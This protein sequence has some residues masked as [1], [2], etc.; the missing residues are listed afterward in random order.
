VGGEPRTVLHVDMDAFFVAV[1]LLRRPELGGRP[2]VVGGAGRRGVVAAAS[3]EARAHGVFSAMPSARA[4]QLCPHAVF[5]PG[6]HAAY[7]AVSERVMAIFRSVTPLVEPLSLDE[8]FLDVSGARRSLGDGPTIAAQLRERVRAEEGL[9]CSVG[10]APSKFLAK[11]AS[12]TAKPRA[13]AS[14]PVPGP[15]VVEVRPGHELEFLH[16]LPVSALWGV[17]PVTLERLGRLGV[18]TVGEL[19]RLP[20]R[21]LVATLG[22]AS[23]TQLH[24]LASGI[25]ERPV[26]PDVRPKSV[27]HEETYSTDLVDLE[28]IDREVVRQADAV[29]ARLRKHHLAGRTV[30]VKVRFPDFRTITRSITLATPVDTGPHLARA[31]KGLLA[32]LDLSPGVRLLG[33]GVSG[34][35]DDAA[36]QLTFDTLA[37]TDDPDWQEASRAVDRIRERYGAEAIGPAAAAR[38]DGIR[39]VRRGAQQWGPGDEI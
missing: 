36:Q 11:L 20:V 37:G 26:V 9:E 7:A 22:K 16:P 5:L 15:A 24:R 2:V 17:G 19:A 12:G 30:N 39:L 25:D 34:L 6:D 21:T 14:G 13:S 8:A 23:G 32:E 31:A 18:S 28:R 33:V 29:A 35:S 27:S 1:E 10:V 4:Q 3:Y 38:P